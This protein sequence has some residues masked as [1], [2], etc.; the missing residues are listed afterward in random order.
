MLVYTGG[1]KKGISIQSLLPAH[2]GFGLVSIYP[3][4]NPSLQLLFG[5]PERALVHI[6][7]AQTAGEGGRALAGV[8]VE[9]V[10]A[11]GA[12]LAQVAR[13][14]VDVDLAVLA[15]V[16]W[17]RELVR[18]ICWRMDRGLGLL[19]VYF[20]PAYVSRSSSQRVYDEH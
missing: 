15:A 4:C 1:S 5:S 13:A 7:L 19:H 18:K 10:D 2:V 9:P 14:V 11:G 20:R 6:S 12:V 16:T 17:G 3:F 8:G